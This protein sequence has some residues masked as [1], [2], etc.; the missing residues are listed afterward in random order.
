MIVALVCVIGVC[1][2]SVLPA[3][4]L[5][6]GPAVAAVGPAVVN[7]EIDP[8]PQYAFAYNIQDAIT[9]DQKSQQETR[10]GDVVKGNTLITCFYFFLCATKKVY[11]TLNVLLGSYSLVEPDGSIRTVLYT[12]DPINGFQAI[13]EKTPFVQGRAVVP[14]VPARVAA[15]LATRVF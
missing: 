12:A 9:G 11:W 3:R 7:T 15:P 8:A 14:A 5:F 4:A 6:A 13:V 1:H 2:C 10:D